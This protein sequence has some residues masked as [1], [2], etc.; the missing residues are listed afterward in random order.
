MLT[1]KRTASD[2]RETHRNLHKAC[3]PHDC[4]E[5]R[6]QTDALLMLEI[7]QDDGGWPI[8]AGWEYSGK[9]NCTWPWEIPGREYR[10]A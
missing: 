1:F 7:K 5:F 10:H 2:L 4:D 6:R 9:W 3:I 8:F